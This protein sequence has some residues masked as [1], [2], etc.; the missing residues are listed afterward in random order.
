MPTREERHPT[1]AERSKPRVA[2]AKQAKGVQTAA[3]MEGKY[4]G[5]RHHKQSEG[6]REPGQIYHEGNSKRSI[7]P[8]RHETN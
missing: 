2:P 8:R 7:R 1:T 5:K 6:E 3:S 4:E